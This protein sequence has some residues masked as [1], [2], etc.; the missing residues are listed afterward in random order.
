MSD[1]KTYK[2]PELE[3]LGDVATIAGAG[4]RPM[5]AQNHGTCALCGAPML[6]VSEDENPFCGA[7][8]T[9]T[10]IQGARR[11]GGVCRREDF[12]ILKSA[13]TLRA[14]M[15]AV[16]EVQ[17]TTLGPIAIAVALAELGDVID[18]ADGRIGR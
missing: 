7:V 11:N 5:P 18:E 14:V 15:R 17:G 4:E 2:R 12:A 1:R 10:E 16:E 6:R 9:H 8:W 13:R 3:E